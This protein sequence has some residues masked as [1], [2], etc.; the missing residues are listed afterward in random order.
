MGFFENIFKNFVNDAVACTAEDIIDSKIERTIQMSDNFGIHS[1]ES[2][3]IYAMDH[4]G[5]APNHEKAIKM[6]R[7][8]DTFVKNFYDKNHI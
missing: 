2:D 3:C 8:R 7:N 4:N 6:I 5:L 1:A